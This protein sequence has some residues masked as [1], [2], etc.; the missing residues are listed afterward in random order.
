MFFIF[1]LCFNF[2]LNEVNSFIIFCI[3][4][5]LFFKIKVSVIYECL[6]SY[7]YFEFIIVYIIYI[8]IFY[9]FFFKLKL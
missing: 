8:N 6:F 9:L 3:E 7:L 4:F 5:F 1:M 2:N